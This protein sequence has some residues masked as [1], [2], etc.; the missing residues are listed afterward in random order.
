MSDVDISAE[1]V[2][3]LA[4][5]LRRSIG[6]HEDVRRDAAATLR[7]LRAAL[8]AAETDLAI[9]RADLDNSG[10][11]SLEI[12]AE[13]DAALAALDAAERQVEH[14]GSTAD[15]RAVCITMLERERDAALAARD[16][17]WRA[18]VAF[19]DAVVAIA[20][21][22]QP[23]NDAQ[24]PQALA[25]MRDALHALLAGTVTI[26]PPADLAA[27]AAGDAV[28][29]EREACAK[30]C[31]SRVRVIDEIFH[32]RKPGNVWVSL[33]RREPRECAALIRA[34]AGA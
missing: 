17:A 25:E 10:A 8:D 12:A 34:R 16:A 1:A 14:Y 22:F 4:R 6:Q 32:R 27:E 9:A 18:Q 26:A 2:E 33:I 24:A 13:R 23:D 5:E 31:E 11:T 20:D 28:A 3:R 15:A 7:A 29:Q 19:R 30:L 21:D